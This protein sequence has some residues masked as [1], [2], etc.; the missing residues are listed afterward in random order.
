MA[1]PLF[2]NLKPVLPDRENGSGFL[3]IGL[4]I[5]DKKGGKKSWS[6]KKYA[7]QNISKVIKKHIG[8]PCSW[9]PT[10]YIGRQSQGSKPAV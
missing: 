9:L 2:P 4:K 7:V 3:L 8:L 10:G 6:V 1:Q 5:A